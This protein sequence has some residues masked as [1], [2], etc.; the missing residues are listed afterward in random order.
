MYILFLGVI[1]DTL[2]VLLVNNVC[3]YWYYIASGSLPLSL[4]PS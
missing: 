4:S 1:Y 3:F 2:R